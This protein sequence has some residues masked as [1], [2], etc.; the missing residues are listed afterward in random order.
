MTPVVSLDEVQ[1]WLA[2]T[3]F[4]LPALDLEL[5]ETSRTVV[6]GR[7]E[8]R[9]DVSTWVDEGTTPVLVR[10]VVAIYVA[11]MEYERA[12][13]EDYPDGDSYSKRLWSRMETLING[14]ID[15]NIHIGQDQDSTLSALE[16]PAF[17]PMDAQDDWTP[18]EDDHRRQA[19]I[20]MAF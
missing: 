10:K 17:F 7:L 1:S 3:K 15:D 19:K 2:P 8:D 13:S 14:I 11:I 18:G 6:F 12:I 9:F 5:E 16:S 4:D 20:G